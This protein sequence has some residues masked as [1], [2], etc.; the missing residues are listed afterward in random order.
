VAQKRR[1]GARA[2]PGPGTA[3]YRQTLDSLF[4][5][6]R[7]GIRPGLEVV[8]ALLAALGH[9]QR[10]F[11]S[12]H[13][14][15]SKGKGSTAA[16]TEAV[17]R[18]HG[19]RTGLFTSPHLSSY[20]DRM[21]VDRTPID[22]ATV[23]RG[24]AEID[25]T[26]R[27]LLAAGTIDRAPTFFEV[28]TVLA[29][30]WFRAQAVEAGVIEVG[31]GGRLDSTNVLA[32]RV[33]VITTV[34]LEHT[35]LLGPTVE[36][37]AREKVGIFHPGMTGV[38]GRLPAP[39]LAAVEATCDRLGVPLWHL[40]REVTFDHR[41][42][43]AT[44][45]SLDVRLP[46][47]SVPGLSFPLWGT[48]QAANASLAVA[49]AARFLASLD[50]GLS[51]DATR[52]GLA[53]VRWPGRLEPVGHRP[54]LY[55]DV[56]HTPESAR[57]VAESL[58]E[59]FPLADPDESVVV[60]GLLRGKEVGRILDALSPLARTLI[61]VPV[62][63]E[64]GVPPAELRVQAVGRFPRIVVARSAAE[65]VRLGRAATGPD[66]FTLVVG[67]DYLIGELVRGPDDEEPDLSD[68]GVEGPTPR[69]RE[70]P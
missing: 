17:L 31:M 41:T 61:V 60:F 25:A 58:G 48:F 24:V 64:R 53:D 55:Y 7:F 39:A 28:T 14:T 11:P 38:V 12:V 1:A 50:R 42:L 36:A 65:G 16:L 51:A 33:G 20:R 27:E 67:S 6:R 45:Q 47:T 2:D 26:A 10:S 59:L 49:A 15:G 23:V 19:L 63:S 22:R 44:G 34:E 52:R 66:G 70:A 54:D 32:S 3:E 56:A 40:G 46:G 29:F 5:R 43:S 30:T 18:A 13:I 57:A 8:E 37:I 21:Q 35:E 4:A 9:P 62:R 68:P 69:G